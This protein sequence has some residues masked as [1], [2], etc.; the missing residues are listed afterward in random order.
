M[1]SKGEFVKQL[2]IGNYE[3][4]RH[5]MPDDVICHGF[6]KIEEIE[7]Q[8]LLYAESGSY[9]LKGHIIEFKQS[10]LIHIEDST[11]CFFT[12]NNELMHKIPLQNIDTSLPISLD[13]TYKCKDDIYDVSFSINKGILQIIYVIQGP[14][15]DC[16]IT[17]DYKLHPSQVINL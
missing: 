17:T 11:F 16:V 15:K 7:E 12:I 14:Y 5:L 9:Q 6:A 3:L 8:R 13:S 4:T 1:N 10:Y 2:L